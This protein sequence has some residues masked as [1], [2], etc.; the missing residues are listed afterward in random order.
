MK[1]PREILLQHHRT[2]EPRLDAIRRA[3]IA[4]RPMNQAAITMDWPQAVVSKLWRELI[5]PARRTWVG[6]AGAWI[7]IVT[8]NVHVVGNDE[9]AGRRFTP[10]SPATLLALREQERKFTE[11]AEPRELR[12]ADRPKPGPPRPRSQARF[13][14][15]I[16]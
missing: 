11:L 14:F 10:P 16:G 3:A 15:L 1:T 8:V 13:G 6:L 5:W 9:V 7:V 12:E 4:S 2:A